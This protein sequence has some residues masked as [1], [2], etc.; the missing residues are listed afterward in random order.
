LK[1]EELIKLDEEALDSINYGMCMMKIQSLDAAADIGSCSGVLQDVLR[2]EIGGEII[3]YF[4][5][6][7]PVAGSIPFI[8]GSLKIFKSMLDFTKQN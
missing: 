3:D 2:E 8:S 5:G 7:N 4:A 1:K 6:P